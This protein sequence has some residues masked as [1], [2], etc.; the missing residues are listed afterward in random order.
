M[1]GRI[2]NGFAIIKSTDERRSSI[3]QNSTCTHSQLYSMR[4]LL[5]VAERTAGRNDLAPTSERGS[6][7]FPSITDHE[8]GKTVCVEYS[9]KDSRS[10]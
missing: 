10:Q 4:P 1:K 5:V 8:Y 7:W 9:A 3:P 6:A 2:L